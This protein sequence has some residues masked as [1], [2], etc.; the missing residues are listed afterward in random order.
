MQPIRGFARTLLLA[1]AVIALVSACSSSAASP[2]ASSAAGITVTGAWVR[3]S[4]AMTGALGG[5]MVIKNNSATPDTL[6]SASSPIAKTVQLHETKMVEGSAMPSASGMGGMGGMSAEPSMA[7]GSAMPSGG[8]MMTM[9]EIKSL[10]IPA[11][12]T[13]EFKPGSYH[14]MFMDLV[15]TPAAGSTI[16]LTLTFKNAGAITVKAEVRAQ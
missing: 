6:L 4:T 2:A 14:I 12:G 8:G 10:D 1:A 15:S 11:N 16:D 9:V 7:M 5:Y 13:V 3:N